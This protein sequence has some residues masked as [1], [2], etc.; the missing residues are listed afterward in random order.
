MDQQAIDRIL[1]AIGNIP[2][3]LDREALGSELDRC[4]KWH[5]VA[6][7][8]TGVP[9]AKRD[10]KHL[11]SINKVAR[12]LSHL[13]KT[14]Y[15]ARL[16]I[17]VEM[18]RHMDAFEADLRGLIETTD[19]LLAPHSKAELEKGLIAAID[20]EHGTPQSNATPSTH[21]WIYWRGLSCSALSSAPSWRT[22]VEIRNRKG[23]AR[24]WLVGRRLPEN[25][26]A[27]LRARATLMRSKGG[28]IDSP[29][30]R[31]ATQAMVELGIPCKPETIAKA[32]T[33]TRTGRVRRPGKKKTGRRS[34][35]SPSRPATP[36][37]R[38]R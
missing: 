32:V 34:R 11:E 8:V 3:G 12:R 1:D 33:A 14:D 28:E 2:E 30:I 7:D 6:I 16:E 37:A 26:R 4:A 15:F 20:D 27:A 22:L 10:K 29:Y 23:S 19:G 13:L 35:R 9:Q 17:A 25:I 24:E 38:S 36:N 5:E 18:P 31:F 21:P